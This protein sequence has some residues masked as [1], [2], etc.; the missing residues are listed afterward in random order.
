MI[1]TCSYSMKIGEIRNEGFFY[2]KKYYKQ[3][4]QVLREATKEEYI[5]DCIR[6]LGYIDLSCKEYFYEVSVD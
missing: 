1:F 3:P 6:L 4:F 5:Q 2:D